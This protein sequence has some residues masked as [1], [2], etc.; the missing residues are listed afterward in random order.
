M[1][2]DIVN[3]KNFYVDGKEK[4]IVIPKPINNKS[5][6]KKIYQFYKDFSWKLEIEEFAEI[7]INNRKVDVEVIPAG[8]K[9]KIEIEA[10]DF[11]SLRAALNSFL[12][13]A[14]C[15]EGVLDNG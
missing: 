2:K 15:A 10:E 14:Y 1:K 4:I 6:K 5:L 3:Y 12:G 9:V 13:W 7:N 8:E 11:T